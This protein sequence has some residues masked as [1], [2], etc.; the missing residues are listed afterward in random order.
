MLREY[1]ENAY[2]FWNGIYKNA[3]RSSIRTDDWLDKFEEIIM[4]SSKPVLDL[5]CG[6]GNDTLCLVEKGREVISCDQSQNAI[7]NIIKNWMVFL[8]KMTVLR[9]S[10]QICVCIILRRKIPLPFFR[11]LR[12]Y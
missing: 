2:E 7:E 12:G 3:G 5:G 8:L 11:R 9:W 10:S 4:A 1:R 6:G